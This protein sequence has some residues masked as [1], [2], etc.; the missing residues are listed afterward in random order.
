M[1]PNVI[2]HKVIKIHAVSIGEPNTFVIVNWQK[3]SSLMSQYILI[4]KS[5]DNFSHCK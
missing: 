4:F 5:Q 2:T 3:N 1:H